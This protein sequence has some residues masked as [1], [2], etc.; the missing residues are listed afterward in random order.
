MDNQPIIFCE[1]MANKSDNQQIFDLISEL[2]YVI[3]ERD[4]SYP[5]AI[6]QMDDS[7]IFINP[8]HDYIFAPR[9]K[10]DDFLK[11]FNND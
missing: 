8:Q 9:N 2:D 7:K 6:K 1:V 3:L 4:Q 11:H 5:M 10:S